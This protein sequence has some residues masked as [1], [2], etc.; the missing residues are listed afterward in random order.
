MTVMLSCTSAIKIEAAAASKHH[1]SI[2]CAG[3]RRAPQ[4][5]T[6]TAR[7]RIPGSIEKLIAVVLLHSN[8]F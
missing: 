8:R 6:F 1:A 4:K 3:Q 2:G 7:A 5:N